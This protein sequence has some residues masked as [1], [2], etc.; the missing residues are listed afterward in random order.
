LFLAVIIT[1]LRGE[2]ANLLSIG[3]IDLGIIVDATVIMV[4]NIFRHL[5]HAVRREVSAPETPLSEKLRRILAAAVEVDRPI[6]FSV[7]ITIAAF[8]PLFTMQ[9]VEGQIFGPM[10]RTYAYAL[11]GAVIAT[12][13]VTPVISSLLLPARV[14]EV[15]TFLVRQLRKVYQYVLPLAVRHY[16]LSA[17][18]AIVLLAI[19]GL[20]AARLGTEFLPKLEEGNLWI[21]GVMPPT[22]TLEGG[23]ETVAR[24]RN[25]IRSYD[26]V[27][28]VFSEQG[29]GE[30]GTDPDG[31]FLVEFFVPLKPF[32]E[33]PAGLTKQKLIAQMS[34]R[35]NHEIVGV[36]FNFSQYIQDNIEEAV[37]GVKGENSVKIFGRDLSQ[38]ERLSQ[39]VKTEIGRV[40]G[41]RDPAAFNLIG[42]PNLIIRID[43]A[44]AARYGISVS[45][46]NAVVQAAIGGQEITRVYE[47]EMNFALTVRLAPRYRDDV[48]A[49]RTVPVAVPNDDPKS[50]T[51]Y[52]ALKD[53]AEVNLESGASYIYRENSQRF[54][55]LKYSVRGRDLGSTVAEAQRH[56]AKAVPLP[57]G[58]RVDWTGEYGALVEA[59]KRLA[60]IVPLSLL[61]IMMLLY[62]LF[63]SVRD[64]LIAL[65]GIPFAVSGGIIGLYVAGLNASVS[66]AVGFISLFGVSAM[67][68][69]L[70]VSYIRRG[71]E[72]GRGSENAIIYAGEARMR[73]I[74]MTGF[75]ACIGL[76]PA[77][78]STGIGSQVQQPLAC[79]I[80]GGMLLSPFC[81]L[82]VIPIFSRIFMPAVPRTGDAL[83]GHAAVH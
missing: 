76:V 82:L 64:S 23:I 58:Y 2:S 3:A 24:I 27:R 15:E 31:S 61:L 6:F 46:V 78:V 77:A 29:R 16:G 42:Q 5:A 9:G 81:S 62:G 75:S 50:P 51:T 21:R 12:F 38:L 53:V 70:L 33:W 34:E 73:Q 49:I 47:G 80:V 25:I 52:I 72:E 35:L 56:L 7:M 60:L 59:Q 83:G 14:N 36:E 13:T 45:D 22:I 71:L 4:E 37:S 17:T 18:I 1:V 19:C 55:P 40:P 8:L 63:N 57:Q 65:S 79:V 32:N 43:R 30:D 10:S 41:V 20:L 28:T 69:I 66:A 67:D 39:S 26:P 11:L 54:V 44:K 68:G 48:S 74:F